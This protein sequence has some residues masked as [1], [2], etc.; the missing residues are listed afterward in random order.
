VYGSWPFNVSHLFEVLNGFAY[1]WVQRFDSFTDLH[2]QLLQ[3][4]PVV[5]S[6]RGALPG[7]LKSFPHGHLLVVVGFDA[8]TNEVICHDP[9]CYTVHQVE[10][11]YSLSHFI[12]AWENSRRLGYCISPIKTKEL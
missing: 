10:K 3:N 5:V 4:I 9:A 7:A 1:A 11:K 2:K 12:A 8:R 6:V